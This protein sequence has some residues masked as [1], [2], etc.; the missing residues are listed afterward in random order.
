MCIYSPMPHT[1]SY[2]ALIGKCALIRSNTVCDVTLHLK[3][4]C[5]PVQSRH[6]FQKYEYNEEPRLQ[7]RNVSVCVQ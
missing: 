3:E 7:L 4:E 2:C 6:G 1:L 5:L